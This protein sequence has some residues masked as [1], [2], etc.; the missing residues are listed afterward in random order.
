M[1]RVLTRDSLT[2][3]AA[4]GNWNEFMLTGRL[5]AGISSSQANLPLKKDSKKAIAKAKQA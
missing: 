5:G 3:P 4:I 2:K 1:D